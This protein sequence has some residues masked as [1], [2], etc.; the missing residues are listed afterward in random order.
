MKAVG[1]EPGSV[2]VFRLHSTLSSVL[3]NLNEAVKLDAQAAALDPLRANSHLNLG[4]GCTWPD[5]M[6]TSLTAQSSGTEPTGG[7]C[8]WRPG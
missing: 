4:Y 3:G 1:L 8:S 5:T 6:K 7:H 2:D